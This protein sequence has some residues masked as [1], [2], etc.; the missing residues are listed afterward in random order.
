MPLICFP[1]PLVGGFGCD[2]LFLYGIRVLA[3]Q[4]LGIV[5][6]IEMDHTVSGPPPP[7]HPQF[8][9]DLPPELLQQGWR[10]YWS[11]RENRPY[12]FNRSVWNERKSR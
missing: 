6:E 1:K 7:G 3:E 2:E 4:L 9:V 5:L 12:F 11:R 8:E 10:K